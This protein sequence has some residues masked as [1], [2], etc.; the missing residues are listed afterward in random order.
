M[1]RDV[2]DVGTRIKK[3]WFQ[4]PAPVYV[5]VVP[6]TIR[7]TYL[8]VLSTLKDRDVYHES[9]GLDSVQIMRQFPIKTLKEA[10]CLLQAKNAVA[11][12]PLRPFAL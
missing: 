12:E 4:I 10:S 5:N 11:Q 2:Y 1:W 9:N 3:I 8:T 6:L 7:F